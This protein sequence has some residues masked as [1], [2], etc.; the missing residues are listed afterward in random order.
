MATETEGD[1]ELPEW[2][3]REYLEKGKGMTLFGVYL[4]GMDRDSLIASVAYLAA[5][6]A[7][8]AAEL[9]RRTDML[10]S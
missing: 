1:L 4:E 8:T 10:L 7:E 9:R 2:L 6:G 5:E 3:V